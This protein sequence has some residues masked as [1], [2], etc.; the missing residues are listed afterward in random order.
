MLKPLFIVQIALLIGT[1][2][3]SQRKGTD[4]GWTDAS[5]TADWADGS[6]FHGGAFSATSV[7]QP[8][9]PFPRVTSETVFTDQGVAIRPTAATSSQKPISTAPKPEQF[10]WADGSRFHGGAFSATSVHQPLPPFPRVT[11]ETVVT[12]QGVAIRPTAATSSEKPISTAPKPEQFSG[13]GSLR[14]NMLKPIFIAQIALLIG[15]RPPSQRKGTNIGWTDASITADWADGSRFH[16]GAFSATSVHQPLPPF[17]RVTSETVITDQGVAIRPTAA[18]SSEKPISTAPKPEQFSGCG[19]LRYNMPKPIFIAQIAL[20]IGTRP[21]S[22]RKGTD[23]GWTDAS[24]TADWADGSRFHG[25]AFS[26]TSVHQPLPPF[27]R[28]TTETVFTDQGVAIRPTAATSS[29]KPISTAPEPEQFSGCG[30][31]R[32]NMLKLIFIVQIALLIGTRPP[33]QRKGTD[34][35]WTD[36]S[37]TADWADGSRFHGGAFSATSVH[38]PLPPFPRVT[39]ETVFTDQGVAIRPTAATSSEKPIST[40]PKPEQFSG[41]GSLRYNMLKLIFI[42]QIALLIGT[43]PPSQRKGTDIGWT[44]ASITADWADGSRFHGGAFSATSVHQPLPPLPRVTSETVI[45]DQGVDIRPT[46]ATSS[47]KPIS[48]APEPEQFSGCG[49]LRNIMLKPLFIIQIAL[50]IG[51]RPPSQ[52]KGTDI[53]WTDASI[54]ADWADGSGFHGGAF[55]ATSVHQ[56][57]PP[58]P[59]VTSETVITDQGVAIRPTAATSSEKPIS[60][61]PKL[62]QFSGCGSL[63]DIMLKPLFIIQIALLIGTRPPSQRKGTDIGWTDASITADWADGSRFHGGAFSATSVHQPLPPLPRVTSETVITDQGV[64]IRP[65]AATSSEKP[66]STAPKPEQFSGCGSLRDIMLKPLFIVQIALL[67]GTR[68]PSQRKWTDIGW[69]DASITADWADGSRFHGGAFSATPVH[70]PLPPLPRVTSETVITDQGVAIRPTAATS[71]EKPISTAP[72]PEQFS[73]CGSLRD[74][75]LKPLF[76]VQIALLI[77]TRPP[78][79]HKGTDIGWTDALITADWADGSRFHGGAFSAT[80]VHQ[81]LPPLPRVTS[82]TV[83]TDQAVAIR[84]TAATSSEKPISTAPKPERFSGCGSLRDNMLKPLFIVQIALLI[85]TRPPSQRKG[86]DIGWA[87]ASITADWA[88]GS[89]FHGGAF[90]ATSVHQPLPPLPRVTSETV[91]TDQGVAIRPT[92]ATSS[93]KPIS[94]APKPEQFSGCGGLRDIMLKPLFIVQWDPVKNARILIN[95]RQRDDRHAQSNNE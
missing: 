49:S 38:Q 35:G 86:T 90:S 65:T 80:S 19:S 83:I 63:R 64:A 56:P 54:I 77:G 58:L 78:S 62:E 45:T 52:R 39:S 76:I 27:P 72:K 28:V 69:T 20:L 40:A 94:T 17:P 34:I 6:R 85:G 16:G 92:A 43:R 91:I 61:A 42:V 59:R 18:T 48:T 46:A 66:I 82:E 44:D 37:I 8:L 11:S 14:Y 2:P 24:I 53:G 70:Q 74:N 55:S 36:A 73:G 25:G 4:I 60:T 10:N 22:Q 7:H 57:L 41:C 1:R 84:P 32:Y 79:Q 87:D 23:I 75:M 31:L 21:P 30:S 93:E 68:P 33:S 13:C 81:P 29:E 47:E 5:I 3:P 95:S 50:L 9:P 26:A 15:T 89:R 12:D 88:D 67:I 71:S 51:T